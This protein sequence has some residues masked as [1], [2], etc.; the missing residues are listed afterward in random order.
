MRA[1]AG[2]TRSRGSQ[3][4][5]ALVIWEPLLPSCNIG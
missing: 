3:K 2:G 1:Q 4:V 5:R